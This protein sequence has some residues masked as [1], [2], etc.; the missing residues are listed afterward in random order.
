MGK[1]QPIT[2]NGETFPTKK[3]FQERARK[4]L[5][6]CDPGE[7]VND[8]DAV[9]LLGLLARHPNAVEKIGVGISHF[10]TQRTEY[11]NIGFILIRTDGTWTDFS[12]LHCITAKTQ[13]DDVKRA[14]RSAV[15]KQIQGFK[16]DAF[17]DEKFTE[18]D[19]L[20]CPVSGEQVTRDNCHVDHEPPL[21][22]ENL[23][24]AFLSSRGTVLDSV[25]VTGFGDG[26]VEKRIADG[27][28]EK[29]WQDYH[30]KNA[31]LRIVSK[32]ANLGTIRRLA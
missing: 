32:S 23:L 16:L 15:H 28:L 6:S 30:F 18:I 3:A 5:Y 2:V 4:I 21:T 13:A 31:N 20:T 8:A 17:L 29:A 7:R 1:R 14:F 9:F 10:G 24:A 11:G 27:E 19:H 26:E 22:F 12:F 25:E